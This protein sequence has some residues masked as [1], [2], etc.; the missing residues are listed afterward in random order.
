MGSDSSKSHPSKCW[1]EH[2]HSHLPR[3]LSLPGLGLAKDLS[4]NEIRAESQTRCC[5]FVSMRC[6]SHTEPLS[7]SASCSVKGGEYAHP[8]RYVCKDSNETGFL[9]AHCKQ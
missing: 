2:A 7:A 4:L 1:G 6:R 3:A 8:P 5:Y 9:R